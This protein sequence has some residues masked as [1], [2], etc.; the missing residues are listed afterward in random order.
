MKYSA[1]SSARHRLQRHSLVPLVLTPASIL[2]GIIASRFRAG[3]ISFKTSITTPVK[4]AHK[5]YAHRPDVRLQKYG[6]TEMLAA[7]RHRRGFIVLD[8]Q[9]QS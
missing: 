2:A 9:Y 4:Y 7:D 1:F 8:A 6:V 3:S 5:Y